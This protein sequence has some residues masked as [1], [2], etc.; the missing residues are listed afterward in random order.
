M[1]AK[2]IYR[3]KAEIQGRFIT[4]III[5]DVGVSR[6]YPGG[7]KYSLICVDKKTMKKI[8]ID[9]HSPKGHHVHIDDNEMSYDFNTTDKLI[10]DFKKLVL[11][12]LGVKL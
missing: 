6:S 10:D 3:Q 4:E 5:Y 11:D 12:N 2:L 8:L 1:K 7:I 9:N